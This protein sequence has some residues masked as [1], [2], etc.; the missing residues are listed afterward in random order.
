MK[1]DIY[2]LIF[3]GIVFI[4]FLGLAAYMRSGRGSFLI[5]LYV[6]LPADKKALYKE[7]ALCKFSGNLLLLADLFL[8]LIVI[9]GILKITWLIILL[10][11]TLI[12]ISII[13]TVYAF[14]DPRF[15]R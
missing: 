9:V 7:E 10:A 12:L 5:N 8:L 13:A 1:D 11:V 3:C 4:V 2:G 6:F 15:R 14:T